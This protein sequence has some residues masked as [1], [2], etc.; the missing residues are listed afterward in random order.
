MLGDFVEE[1]LIIRKFFILLI[2]NLVLKLSKRIFLGVNNLK[3]SDSEGNLFWLLFFGDL[4]LNVEFKILSRK[5]SGRKFGFRVSGNR[6]RG[7][8]NRNE[9]DSISILNG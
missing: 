9:Y 7:S 1:I 2:I 3:D 4:V 8:D 6:I 5:I